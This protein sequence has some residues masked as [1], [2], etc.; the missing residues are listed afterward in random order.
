MADSTY[1]T[2]DSTQDTT[3][4][5]PNLTSGSDPTSTSPSLWQ[6]ISQALSGNGGNPTALS[7]LFG[8]TIN[9]NIL[10]ALSAIV[11]GLKMADQSSG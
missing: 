1:D 2:G 5:D 8:G 3:V 7:Q 10:L 11:P 9:P 4:Y 6:Q